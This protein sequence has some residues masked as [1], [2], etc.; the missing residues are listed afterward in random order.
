[1]SEPE[2]KE[3]E[4]GDRLDSW[5]QPA[6]GAAVALSVG[7]DQGPLAWSCGRACAIGTPASLQVAPFTWV[8]AVTKATA[9]PI[10]TGR[11]AP[12]DWPARVGSRAF[13]SELTDAAQ[14]RARGKGQSC[15][16]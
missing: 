3:L 6:E 9:S 1:M 7:E 5:L 4:L 2:E 8:P 14:T 12:T 11:S 10:P 16:S 15:G 13:S